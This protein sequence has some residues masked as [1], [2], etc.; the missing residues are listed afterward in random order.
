MSKNKEEE[1]TN[2][3][4]PMKKE[5]FPI[6]S[7]WLEASPLTNLDD[8]DGV[9]ERL[10]LLLHYGSDFGIWG[11]KRRARYWEAL[12]ERVKGAC[13]SGPTL[14]DWWSN[15]SEAIPSQPRNEKE[16]AETALLLSYPHGGLKVLQ[17]F[18]NH[19]PA[20]VLRTR[21][22]AEYRRNSYST[23]PAISRSKSKEE[24]L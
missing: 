6:T 2:I 1:Q 9:A 22:C 21:V 8:A 18:R 23:V 10:L 15:I 17:V 14:M 20:L 19:T 24:N 7:K 12:T 4:F 3:F 16:R 13:Y 11:E 5:A